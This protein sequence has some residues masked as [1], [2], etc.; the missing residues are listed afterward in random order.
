M[1]QGRTSLERLEEEGWT[2]RFVASEPRL[3]E[4]CDLYRE[5]GYEVHLEPLPAETECETC[6]GEEDQ[7]ECRVC[8]D[9][10]EDQYKIIFTRPK[11]ADRMS[12]SN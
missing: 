2:K 12:E 11:G 10:N 1:T 6:I 5:T 3:S 9:G 8:F 4:A 7:G